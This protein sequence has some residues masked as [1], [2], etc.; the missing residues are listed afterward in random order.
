MNNGG[1]TPIPRPS[2]EVAT[3]GPIISPESYVLNL[4]K[5]EEMKAFVAQ[6]EAINEQGIQ[7]Y[8][9]VQRVLQQRVMEGIEAQYVLHHSILHR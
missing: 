5:I 4:T 9:D 8:M 7:Q 2:T 1:Q 6:A 3:T